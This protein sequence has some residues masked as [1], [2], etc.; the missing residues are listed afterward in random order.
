MDDFQREALRRLPLAEAVWTLLRHVVSPEFAAA[1]FDRGRGTGYDGGLSS[2]T[3]VELTTD[4]LGRRRSTGSLLAHRRTP[5]GTTSL[6]SS[7]VRQFGSTSGG[8]FLDRQELIRQLDVARSPEQ[9]AT[10]ASRIALRTLDARLKE[11]SVAKAIRQTNRPHPRPR[12]TLLRL[13]THSSGKENQRRTPAV[14]ACSQQW[15]HPP[16]R[17]HR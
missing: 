13:E 10:A 9:G 11:G 15:R 3:L 6:R 2:C 8:L 7:T 12:R 17:A 5:G 4:R 16:A 14:I 1:L